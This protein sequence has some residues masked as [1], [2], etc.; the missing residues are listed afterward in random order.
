MLLVASSF[1]A[2]E[3]RKYG[4]VRNKIPVPVLPQGATDVAADCGGFVATFKWGDYR[5][6]PEQYVAWLSAW[7]P[8]WAACMDYCCE[9]EITTGKPG[10][11]LA[12]QDKT[13]TMAY[14]FW[15]RWQDAP[16]CWV[17]TIQGWTVADYKRHA[18]EMKP[19]IDAMYAHYGPDS[20]FRVGIGTLC[21]RASVEMI[22][23]VVTA[24]HDILGNVPLHL[25][26]I[27]LSTMQSPIALPESVV[28][29]DS[30]AW[31]GMWG[32]GRNLWKET[33]MT[34]RQ[35][36]LQVALPSYQAR[37]ERALAVPK[38]ATLPLMEVSA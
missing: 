6:T 12:R 14:H 2:E 27:K 29:V 34:Q 38:Q 23:A 16:W 3:V 1:A 36:C 19:L 7:N 30:A 22:R 33:G 18:V 8:S 15:R 21:H 31:N 25:W 20:A 26:G 28:S 9:D 4:H 13:T 5:Y 32:D 17:P 10:I 24:V 35:W 37:L 11:V